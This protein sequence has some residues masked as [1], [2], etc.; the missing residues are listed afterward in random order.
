MGC[1]IHLYVEVFND[2][3]EEY[4]MLHGFGSKRFEDYNTSPRSRNY[5]LFG[6]LAGTRSRTKP[7]CE[8]RDIPID[9]SMGYKSEVNRWNSDGHTHSYYYLNELL[10]NKARLKECT[11]FWNYIVWLSKQGIPHEYIR[12][13]FFFDN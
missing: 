11:S 2:C 8:L 4:Y 7:I 12:L 9:A 13:C 1:D 6:I 10:E 5:E 3:T